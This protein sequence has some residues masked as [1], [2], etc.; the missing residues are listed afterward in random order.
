MPLSTRSATFSARPIA[1]MPRRHRLS[2]SDHDSAR[3]RYEAALPLYQKVGDVLGEANCI[4][5]LGDIALARSDHEGARQRL[6]GGAAALPKG[7]RPCPGE[8]NCIKSLGD[9][10]LARSDHE[11]ARQRYEAALPLYQKGRQRARRGQLHPEP[12]RHR[13]WPLRS[14]R[15][16]PALRG[17]AAALPEGRRR[18]RR[19]QL[20]QEP[21]RHRPSP[22]RSRRRAPA[23]RGGAAALQR[24]AMCS[25]RPIA[26]GASAT[27]TRAGKALATAAQALSRS[28][29]LFDRL[30]RTLRLARHAATPAEA[31]EHR[32]A[33]RQGLGVDRPAGPDRTIPRQGRVTGPAGA[34]A[35]PKPGSDM[36][37]RFSRTIS[38]ENQKAVV[39]S[40]SWTISP[41][42]ISRPQGRRA[43][44]RR[45]VGP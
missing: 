28:Q 10:A 29:A 32:E 3:Q 22:L 21:R 41:S 15:R 19:G 31:A 16:A 43:S 36:Y 13:P 30:D 9:I 2:R 4:K 20:H 25:A 23:L 35:P 12:R 11:G 27:S 45:G 6:R 42:S 7:R 34:S 39:L 37:E 5:S 33:A 14:R 1:C 17:G 18:A 26:S 38:S 8:A 24:S 40:G 44:A